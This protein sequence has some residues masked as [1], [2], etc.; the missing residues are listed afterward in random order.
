MLSLEVSGLK[1]S[2]GKLEVLK[3]VSF[4]VVKGRTLG[5]IG[6]NGAGKTT[7]M[8]I[9]MGLMERDGGEI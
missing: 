4:K 8:K 9:V 7:T 3:D 6:K 1:K 2:F 5:F